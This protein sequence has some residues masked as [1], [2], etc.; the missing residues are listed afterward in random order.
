VKLLVL[1]VVIAP[2]SIVVTPAHAWSQSFAGTSD[3]NALAVDG[4]TPDP[5]IYV[6]DPGSG[7]SADNVPPAM[8]TNLTGR[9]IEP[10]GGLTL[11]WDPNSEIDL[12]HYVIYR[13]TDPGFVPGPGNL[14]GTSTLPTVDDP[15]WTWH[16]GYYYKVAAVDEH[17]NEGPPALLGSETVTRLTSVEIPD[18]DPAEKAPG[19]FN[20]STMIAFS[21][22]EP[23]FVELSIYD[24]SG[25]L[26]KMLVKKDHAAGPHEV[27]WDGRD[28]QNRTVA[29]GVYFY[30][31]QVGSES[32]SRKLVLLK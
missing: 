31:L 20:P 22:R 5:V 2:L 14:L 12:D 7:H 3:P 27:M 29:S 11:L 10:P 15:S 30:R 21:L 24:A 19:P 8:V 9:Q 4:V 6:S 16:S 25:E 28:E 23:A 18:A 32:F 1:I 17:E 26:V 13:G